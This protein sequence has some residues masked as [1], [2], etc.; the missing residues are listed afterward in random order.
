MQLQMAGLK[1]RPFP[2]GELATAVVAL[3]QTKPDPA[4]LIFDTFKTVDAIGRATV[5]AR[6]PVRPEDRFKRLE[7][8][9]FVVEV[10]FV[11]HTGHDRT[12]SMVPI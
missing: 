8:R 1:Y 5:R 9:H 7:G 6:R 4:L 2:D 3:P 10:R 12:L 11:Q